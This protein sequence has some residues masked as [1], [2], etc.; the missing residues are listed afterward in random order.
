MQFFLIFLY[1][2]SEAFA[3]RPLSY[4]EARSEPGWGGHETL[5]EAALQNLARQNPFVLDHIQGI[6]ERFGCQDTDIEVLSIPDTWAR[7]RLPKLR[8]GSL[9]YVY[10]V[11]TK[12][13]LVRMPID[14][15]PGYVEHI[16]AI[17]DMLFGNA[18]E[19][20]AMLPPIFESAE[21]SIARPSGDMM[22]Y[23]YVVTAYVEGKTV[24]QALNE[25][26]NLALCVLKKVLA[27][28]F[29]MQKRLISAMD[30]KHEN[31]LITGSNG[32]DPVQFIDYLDVVQLL[33]QANGVA[34]NGG[35]ANDEMNK[36]RVF[37][38]DI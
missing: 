7:M 16:N 14:P 32:S 3:L 37:V 9:N 10:Y 6:T 19:S 36:L 13:I 22:H 28:S 25:N 18:E 12:N 23:P 11:K 1:T 24:I 21:M 34:H 29:H 27:A 17:R 38:E 30:Y 8:R 15:Q 5:R 26:P 35:R 31:F 4:G 20:P 33:S 2:N